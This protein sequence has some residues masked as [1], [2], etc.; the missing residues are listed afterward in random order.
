MRG[1]AFFGESDGDA[2]AAGA[3]IEKTRGGGPL[4]HQALEKFPALLGEEFGFRARDEDVTVDGDFVP[5]EGG[6]A[7]DVLEG[8]AVTAPLD[9]GAQ[10]IGIL[11][12]ERSGEIKIELEAL[13]LEDV[14]QEKFAL[15]AGGID[16]LSGEEVGAFLNGVQNGHALHLVQSRNE[17][18]RHGGANRGVVMEEN[19]ERIGGEEELDELLTRPSEDLRKFM[20]GV[21]S[22]L[23]VLGAGGKMGPTLAVLA[24]RA[25]EAAGHDL[26]VVAVSRFSNATAQDWLEKQRVKTIA[27]DLLERSEVERLPESANV[28]YLVGLKFGTA[29]NPALT[30]AINTVV[31][32]LVAERYQNARMSAVSTGNVYPMVPVGAGGAVEATPLTPLGEY[33]NAAVARERVLQFFSQKNSTRMALLRLFYAVEM[34]YGVLVDI[35]RKVNAGEEIELANGYFN[36]IWQGDANEMILRALT[37]AESPAVS[38]NLC[39]PQILS[40]RETA[41]HF[42]ELLGKTPR[43]AGEESSTALVANASALCQRLGEPRTASG[44]VMKWIADWVRRGGRD[45]GK[46]THFEVRDG[47]Y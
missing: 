20:R 37:L 18:E 22:P 42:G 39:C 27:C 3:E 25:A 12:C 24:K 33:A 34:R 38:W 41:K 7:E 19:P 23:V 21:E 6:G 8:F 40:V 35:A 31:P 26:E 4:F 46:P 44:Q 5:A 17:I 47:G 9:K 13:R 14:S 30:W 43:F 15:E 11:R 36:C 16:T 45:L 32:A 29:L 1:G 28:I 2:P 10:G